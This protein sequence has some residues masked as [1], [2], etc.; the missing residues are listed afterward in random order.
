[1][2]EREEFTKMLL[3]PHENFTAQV[4]VARITD[5]GRFMADV[6]IQCAA[7]GS[8]FHFLGMDAGLHFAKPMVNPDATEARLPIAPGRGGLLFTSG[9]DVS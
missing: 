5:T 1:M 2:S 7:C 8:P 3:C 6:T 4:N 9:E